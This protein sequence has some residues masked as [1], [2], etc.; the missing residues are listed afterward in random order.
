MPDCVFDS[1]S[2]SAMVTTAA[3]L[4]WMP[5]PELPTTVGLEIVIVPA[6]STGCLRW[7]MPETV[8]PS[9]SSRDPCE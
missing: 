5:M 1:T 6:P 9:I 4:M 3:A 2:D 7:L 8:Q